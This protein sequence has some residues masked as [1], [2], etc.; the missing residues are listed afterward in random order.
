MEQQLERLRKA[1]Q[2]ELCREFIDVASGGR[3]DRPQ[4]EALMEACRAG[5]IER[6]IV[7]RLDRMSRSFVHGADLLSYFSGNDSPNLQALDDNLDLATVGGRLVARVLITLA[8]AE[9]ERLSERVAHGHHYHRQQLKPFGPKPPYGYRYT[10]DRANYELDPATAESA[11]WL[12]Q[13]FIETGMVRETLRLSLQC[14]GKPFKSPSGI[15]HWMLNP[16]LY[17]CRCYGKMLSKEY[18]EGRQHATMRPVGE[19]KEVI[20]DCHEPL[21]SA[22]E[23]AKVR[24]LFEQHK[25]RNRC[26]LSTR[27][28]RELTGLVECSHCHHKLVYSPGRTRDKDKIRCNN[29]GCKLGYKNSI[30]AEEVKAAIWAVLQAN[31]RTI[32]LVA[33]G[34]TI[35]QADAVGQIDDLVQTIRELES[36]KDPDLLDAIETK[37]RRLEKLAK[38]LAKASAELS[39]DG[40]MEAALQDPKFWEIAKADRSMTR[41]IFAEHVERVLVRAKAVETVELRLADGGASSPLG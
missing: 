33:K 14:P 3:D 17:G 20:P 36:R 35:Y 9:V 29:A 7:T 1:A 10:K 12:V 15:M 27:Y 25:N 26:R 19:Y 6:V 41:E 31:W 30:Y 21:I 4:L 2:G 13:H 11:R 39:D 40:Q 18:R 28:V 32:A 38:K 23:H 5:E 37:R 16:S 8:Q 34:Q 24:A 22:V